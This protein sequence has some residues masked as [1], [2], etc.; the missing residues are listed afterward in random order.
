MLRGVLLNWIKRAL[1][2]ILAVWSYG[3]LVVL[4]SFI[5]TIPILQFATLGYMIECSSRVSRNLPWR[6]CIPGTVVARR[7]VI[8]LGC[9]A[10]SWL[11]VWYIADVA[12]T[13][14]LIEPGG[15]RAMQLRF[16]ARVIALGWIAWISWAIFRGGKLRHFAW[17][18]PIFFLKRFWR[19]STWRDAEDRLWNFVVSLRLPTLLW[20]GFFA[21]L[22]AIVWLL[23]PGTMMIIAVSGQ[24]NPGKGLLGAVGV[25]LM[26]WVLSLLPFLQ[27]HFGNQRSVRSL[28]DVKAVRHGMQRAPWSAAWGIFVLFLFATPL[29]LL[30]IER[31]PEELEW[32]LTLFFVF[33]MFPAKLVV[34]WAWRR[35]QSLTTRAFWLWRYVA[36]MPQIAVILTYIGVL[37]LAKFTSWE[38][39]T[40]FYLQHAFLP[41]VPFFVR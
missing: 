18:A 13:T 16:A 11:P 23:I 5:A 34:G 3:C 4:L 33:F 21:A 9:I 7:I 15:D 41:P 27:T 19:L 22:G 39:A 17:P 38:G 36:W 26:V 2:T 14:E 28:F 30:R 35:S 25:L 37:Y 20:L 32:T 40:V 10:L 6:E 1:F 29:Y 24:P 12:Y 8:A 31:I